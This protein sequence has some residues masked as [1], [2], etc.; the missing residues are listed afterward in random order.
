MIFT[1][2]SI[3]LCAIF[4]LA[5]MPALYK[6]PLSQIASYP[7][8][9]RKRVEALPEYKSTIKAL[10]RK[11]IAR[12]IAAVILFAIIFAAIARLS[13]LKTFKKVFANTFM[14]FF[15]VNL[16]DLIVLD[17]IIFCR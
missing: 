9:I 8:A 16:Y 6:N 3:A 11:H 7:T 12:K 14:L 4:T 2:E 15:V 17:L 10:E 5:I 13:G 1:I